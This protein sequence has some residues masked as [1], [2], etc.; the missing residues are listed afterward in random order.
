VV[1]YILTIAVFF[2][3]T[4]ELVIA[5]ILNVLAVQMHISVAL[6]GQLITVYSLA[7]AIGAPI[8]VS[9]TAR[10]GRKKLLLLAMLVFI[11]GN[12]LSVISSNFTMLIAS[13]IILGM[14]SGVLLVAAFSAAAKM[15]TPERIGSTL[16]TI[17]LGFSS[18]MIL[19]VPIGI[20]LTHLFSWQM[21]FL[22]LGGGSLIILVIMAF[23]LPEIE[24]DAPVPFSRQF[25]VLANPVI[26]SAL[27][28]VLFRETGNSVMFTYLSSFLDTI[29]HQSASHIGFIM[30]TFGIAGAI[31]SCI[32]G[33]AVDK[34]GSIRMIIISMAVHVVT[35]SL[36]PLVTHSFQL[37]IALLS[38][39]VMS[40][41]IM[42]PATQT[43]FIERAPQSSN[44]IISLNTSVTQVGLATG[45]GVGGVA[46]TLNT[47]ALY[48][49]WV[50]AVALIFAFAA[51]LLSFQ[52]NKKLQRVNSAANL[53]NV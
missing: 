41:F 22:F 52:K 42:G 40:M 15:V 5:G 49:P 12:F 3:A 16:G 20:A 24:G 30:L 11:I 19:G 46:V 28:L 37:A 8:V 1:I 53:L 17:I 29:L 31:G 34:W 25:T 44:L 13:R 50:A 10:M 23:M 51:A 2:T 18:A 47:T 38:M 27:L 7:F 6:T 39:W 14:S 36:L 9:L 26:L 43:Y 21:I 45:A 4:S 32:G 35:L 33:S 48:N